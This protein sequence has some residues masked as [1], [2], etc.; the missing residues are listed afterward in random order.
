M[1]WDS[2]S[3]A[4]AVSCPRLWTGT[5]WPLRCSDAGCEMSYG[6]LLFTLGIPKMLHSWKALNALVQILAPVVTQLPF[7]WLYPTGDKQDERAV[8]ARLR[9]VLRGRRHH[10][11]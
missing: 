8:Q 3:R 7:E 11:R 5:G 9:E 6:D 2:T 1:I 10:R 4:S